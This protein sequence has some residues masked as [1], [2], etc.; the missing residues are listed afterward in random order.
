MIRGQRSAVDNLLQT[1]R[2]EAKLFKSDPNALAFLHSDADG[3]GPEFAFGRLSTDILSEV[4]GSIF[5]PPG[6]DCPRAEI[7]ELY[8]DEDRKATAA[9]L[10]HAVACGVCMDQ[11][12]ETLGL[13]SLASRAAT[14]APPRD[15]GHKPGGGGSGGMIVIEAAMVNVT[16]EIAA[17]GGG[18]SGGADDVAGGD[19]ADGEAGRTDGIRA[20]GG[21]GAANQEGGDGADGGAGGNLDGLDSLEAADNGGGGGGGGCGFIAIGTPSLN[22]SSGSISP[23]VS[24]W[25][26]P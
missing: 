19:G 16:G 14:D 2:R 23:A 7:P 11:V 18:G 3:A 9:F 22:A 5:A 17:N 6:A 24:S 25:P 4:R 21:L 26:F 13:P 15:K 10:S 8:E 12:N 1:A 20:K